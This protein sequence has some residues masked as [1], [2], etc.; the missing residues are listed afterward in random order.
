MSTSAHENDLAGLQAYGP[1]DV[2]LP[3]LKLK[4]RETR[5][6]ERVPE[7]AWF[8]TG[9]EEWHALTR[10]LVL[11]EMRKQR[12]VILPWSSETRSRALAERIRDRTGVDVPLDYDGPVCH[13]RDR[14]LP[15]VRDGL[16]PLASSCSTCPLARW[17]VVDGRRRQDCAESYRLLLWDEAAQS[18]CVYYAQGAAIP[19]VKDLLTN[20]QVAARR[21]SRP[22]YGFQLGLRAVTKHSMDGPYWVPQFTR[23]YPHVDP[24]A[25]A[26]FEAV[27]TACTP[28]RAAAA[29]DPLAT[30]TYGERSEGV[31]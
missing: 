8:L 31:A 25:W 16:T 3:R 9:E 12:G 17:Q 24:E 11:L 14:Q 5:G 29:A 21:Y 28:A 15:V 22:V 10:A 1:E 13:S 20:L 4:Q 23:P 2:R 7:G 6:A 19:P 30:R 26:G 27:L 18:P